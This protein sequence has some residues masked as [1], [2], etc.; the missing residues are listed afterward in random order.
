MMHL[1]TFF[2]SRLCLVWK[3]GLLEIFRKFP[4]IGEGTQ[5]G[6][7]TEL[8]ES[9]VTFLDCGLLGRVVAVVETEFTEILVIV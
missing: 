8:I 1:G 7:E 5:N 3:S 4:E 2:F 6:D 9:S